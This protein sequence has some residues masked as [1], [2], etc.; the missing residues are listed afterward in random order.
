MTPAEFQFLQK[1]SRDRAAIVLDDGKAYLV[2]HRLEPVL[3]RHGL[4][5]IGDLVGRLRE[6]ADSELHQ[7]VIEAFTTNETS[8]FRDDRVYNALKET[9]LPQLVES[10]RTQRSLHIWSA[11]CSTGQEPYS[12]AMLLMDL[13]PELDTWDVVIEATD[14]NQ[15]VLRRAETGLYSDLEIKRGVDPS[16]LRFFHKESDGYRISEK[17]RR[18][19]K[20]N[21]LNLARPWNLSRRFDL[22]MLRNVLIYFDVATKRDIL[23]RAR[24]LMSPDGY[25]FLGAAETTVNVDDE[26]VSQRVG[27]AVTYRLKG[28]EAA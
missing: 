5:G 2:E 3:K 4:A 18:M 7:D 24:Q 14:I 9:V 19:V 15:E 23:Q 11:A 26:F 20:F 16:M 1:L 27:A 13:Y 6:R 28:A 22:V 25:L 17:A 21:A 10:R 8:F 12:L